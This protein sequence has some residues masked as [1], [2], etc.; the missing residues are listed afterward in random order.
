MAEIPREVLRWLL[1][2]NINNLEHKRLKWCVSNGVL[3]AEILHNYQP[4]I[5]NLGKFV[6]GQS[7]KV[8]L[9]NWDM[10]QEICQRLC[11]YLPHDIV[12][13][14]VHNKSNAGTILLITLYEIFASKKMKDN[15]V[16]FNPTDLEYQFSLPVYARS[17]LSKF[18]KSNLTCSEIETK[19]D[20]YTNRKK[21]QLLA[22]AYKNMKITERMKEP[23]RFRVFR[24]LASQCQRY[25]SMKLNDKLC[26]EK[27]RIP[28]CSEPNE[29][30]WCS[31]KEHTSKSL[32]TSSLSY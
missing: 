27:S 8:K 19:P 2:L 17:C 11:I 7:V 24:S 14:V 23:R 22:L 10:I 21:I 9:Q 1:S 12:E 29:V 15:I 3:V 26:T 30:S 31:L 18:I 20:I 6:D 25:D 28:I 16:L 13:C 5:V 4:G 32:K